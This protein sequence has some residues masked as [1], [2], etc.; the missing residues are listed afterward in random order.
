MCDL[1]E[2][3]M[4]WEDIHKNFDAAFMTTTEVRSQM[5]AQKEMLIS[6]FWSVEGF[7]EK[8]TYLK[9]F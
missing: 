3:R 7:H 8:V 2:C 4:R 9:T 5:W 6:T 1:K